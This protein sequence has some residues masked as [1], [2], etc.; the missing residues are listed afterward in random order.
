MNTSGDAA[1]QIV[2]M[3]LDGVEVAA[4]ITGTG[5]K[6]LAIALLAIMKE[7]NKTA[8]KAR[9]SSMIKS[10]K[11]LNVFSI[12]EKDLK[13]FALEA[14]RYGVLYCV[15]KGKEKG[16]E[17][18]MVDLIVR[19]EDAPKINRIVQNFRLATVDKAKVETQ[20]VKEKDEQEKGKKLSRAKA[21]KDPLS[22]PSSARA[23]ESRAGIT[24]P[25]ERESV[26]AKMN[27]YKEAEKRQ[28]ETARTRSRKAYT[29]KENQIVHCQLKKKRGRNR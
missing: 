4:K 20:I 16:D 28:Q 21:E 1:E 25:K 26:R 8:G 15:V 11:E 29:K 27:T 24:N 6:H 13:K 2:R 17:N 23:K 18:T 5:A 7:E 12:P 14:K 10:G 3:S 9:L 22:E 19:M